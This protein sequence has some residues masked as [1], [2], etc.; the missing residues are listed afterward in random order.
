MC[1]DIVWILVYERQKKRRRR[2][3]MNLYGVRE[4]HQLV[5]VVLFGIFLGGISFFCPMHLM[6][7]KY[8]WRYAAGLTW[9]T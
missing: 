4:A 7:L 3:E 2:R 8:Q 9:S 5:P 6:T 1:M